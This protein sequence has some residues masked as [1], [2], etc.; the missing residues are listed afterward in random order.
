M[1]SMKFR[2]INNPKRYQEYYSYRD[3][4]F[5]LEIETVSPDA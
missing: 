4:N 1:R 2:K 5:T 3:S